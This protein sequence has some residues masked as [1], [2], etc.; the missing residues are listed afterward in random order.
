MKTEKRKYFTI[1]LSLLVI[2]AAI[3]SLTACFSR[4]PPTDDAAESEQAAASESMTEETS[5]ALSV[6]GEKEETEEELVEE[7]QIETRIEEILSSMSLE[8]K[9][10]Q[11][12]IVAPEQLTGVNPVTAAGELT[13][14]KLIEHPV[15]GL[16]Y[17]EANIVSS[18]QI[19][20]MIENT[21]TYANEIEGLPLFLCVDEEGGRVAKVGNNAAFSVRHVPA[22]QEIASETE[23]YEAGAAIGGYLSRLGFNVDFAP[24]ADVLTNSSNMVIGDRSFGNDPEEVTRFAAAFSDGLHSEN[25]LSAF[26]HFPGH[27]ATEADTHE[28]FA[29]A[30]RTYEEL[31]EA[32]LK[33][34]AAAEENGVDFVMAAHI[35]VPEVT[36]DNTPCSLSYKMI[37]DVLRGELGYHGLVITDA[38][39]MGAITEN[40]TSEEAAVLSIQAGVDLLLMPQDLP[41][42]F[43][44]VLQAVKAGEITEERIDESVRRIIRVKCKKIR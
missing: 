30:D 41:A 40:Y 6:S 27:G 29:Y 18:E 4:T 33:P 42:A 8:E 39:Q 14:D 7:A 23:A 34:F 17:F 26:K 16:I 44:G 19:K 10:Y 36:G 37:T 43:T 5:E 32:E 15:G 24:V 38:L 13:R 22:M 12:F 11:M 28:G 21:Q 2:I 1:R 3:V 25:I 20:E 35:S 9:L 31:L